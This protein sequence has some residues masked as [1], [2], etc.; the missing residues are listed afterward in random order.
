MSYIDATAKSISALA[1]ILSISLPA[2]SQELNHKHE[3]HS[4]DSAPEMPS[5]GEAR[6]T[7]LL[8]PD[9]SSK[10]ITYTWLDGEALFE[11]DIQLNIHE[12][13]SATFSGLRHETFA[14]GAGRAKPTY[15]WP[16]NTVYFAVDPSLTN[17]SR[18]YN[19]ID[20]WES[21]TSFRFVETSSAPNYIYF[22]PSTS[23]C[24][25]SVGMVGGPQTIKL[26][27]TCSK[28]NT[29]HEIGH[30]IGLW[31]EHTREDRDQYM[32]INWSNIEANKD[33]NFEI[34]SDRDCD[35]EACDGND[36]ASI[37]PGSIMMYPCDAFNISSANTIN[38][39]DSSWCSDMGQ[40]SGLSDGDIDAV[41]AMYPLFSYSLYT[42]PG[43]TAPDT[44]ARQNG[45]ALVGVSQSITSMD[46]DGDG[47]DELV[48]FNGGS[49][50][51]WNAEATQLLANNP[52][53]FGGSTSIA[54]GDFDG[55][56]DDEIAA[57]RSGKIQVFEPSASPIWTQT[58]NYNAP[59]AITSLT[60]ADWDGDHRD[61]LITLSGMWLHA[62]ALG[63]NMSLE[64]FNLMPYPIIDDI[65]GVDYDG[66]GFDEVMVGSKL[67][68]GLV[69]EL[70]STNGAPIS[71]VASDHWMIPAAQSYLRMTG[72]DYDGD[73]QDEVATFK[74]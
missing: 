25:S 45:L 67:G 56:G 17:T 38:P 50:L 21:K 65:A 72:L 39:Y 8:L 27:S 66:D 11:G 22:T 10:T 2:H 33:H 29:I 16:G 52:F 44:L 58:R 47:I 71:W 49:L 48:T 46:Y 60:A 53:N 19:A 54:G 24:S 74:F 9:G 64:T 69:G 30:A 20:H 4:M 55:D 36:Y 35:G 31:H 41:A 57:L 42:A 23:G 15:F 13:G 37:D 68:I 63:N 32:S 51:I 1:L 18:V 59:S 40:R 5:G 12:D 43:S 3:R 62:Y 61:E 26:K 6:E 14:K 70:Q 73:G 34:Y 7:V 28:G